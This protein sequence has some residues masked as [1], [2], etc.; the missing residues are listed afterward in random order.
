LKDTCGF[1]SKPDGFEILKLHPVCPPSQTIE[2]TQ[3]EITSDIS[4]IMSALRQLLGDLN[5]LNGGINSPQRQVRKACETG[6]VA[7][8]LKSTGM[9]GTSVED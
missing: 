8:N 7:L 9:E 5:E 1:L 2:V 4:Y 6:R 3:S